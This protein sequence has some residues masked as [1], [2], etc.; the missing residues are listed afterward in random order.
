[1]TAADASPAASVLVVG[2]AVLDVQAEP[3]GGA[4]LRAGG[5][6]PG[7]V[8]NNNTYMTDC[9]GGCESNRCTLPL[10]PGIMSGIMLSA[11]VPAG[12]DSLTW[13]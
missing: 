6:V 3:G 1:M 4:A 12:V 13:I 7:R 11:S 10:L 2:G 8:S 9:R 5:S